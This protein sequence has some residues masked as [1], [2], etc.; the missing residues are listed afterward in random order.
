MLTDI[1]NDKSTLINADINNKMNMNIKTRIGSILFNIILDRGFFETVE[2][3]S[4]ENHNHSAFEVHFVTKGAAFLCVNNEQKDIN[5][6]NYYVVAP[7]I[8]H[9]HR[10]N[11]GESFSKCSFRIEYRLL[12]TEEEFFPV[13]ESR[14][15]LEVLRSITFFSSE[16]KNNNLKLL[17]EIS[18]EMENQRLGYYS[19]I[20]SLFTQ[21]IINLIRDISSNQRISYSIPERLFYE[22]RCLMIEDFFEFNYMNNPTAADLARLIHVSVRQLNRILKDNFSVSFKQKLLEKRIEMSKNLLK[23]S[24]LPVKVISERVGYDT[25]SN[26]CTIFKQKNGCTPNEYRLKH[27]L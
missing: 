22:K 6:N 17:H 5:E 18:L 25:E 1:K 21:L 3:L 15:I 9:E 24:A 4:A 11:P 7:G 26:F 27:K 2:G 10:V 20:Q 16:D 8:F 14:K 19:K 13:E 12:D 23:S